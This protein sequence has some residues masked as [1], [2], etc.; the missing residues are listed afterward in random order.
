M[1]M[2]VVGPVNGVGGAGSDR[3]GK[4]HGATSLGSL[5]PNNPRTNRGQKRM[6]SAAANVDDRRVAEPDHVG[7]SSETDGTWVVW[8]QGDDGNPFEV[9]RLS[10]RTK[11]EE[12]AA[13]MEA[14]G[15]RQTYWIA[16]LP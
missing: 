12:L 8:R 13:T 16:P 7:S 6:D 4:G 5:V 15:H 11:A 9:A 2:P 1:A 14:R 3:L 10:S